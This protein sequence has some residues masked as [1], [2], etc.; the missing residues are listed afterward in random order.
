MLVNGKNYITI[1]LENNIVKTI[2]QNLLPHKFEIVELK[3]VED[4]IQAIN[5]MLLRGAP[6]IGVAAAYGIYLAVKEYEGDI[7]VF[8]K[9][10]S[11]KAVKIKSTRPTTVNLSN[12]VDKSL[13]FIKKEKDIKSKIK[14]ALNFALN[15][16]KSEIDSCKK[17]GEY[18]LDIIKKLDKNNQINILTHCNAGW[19]ACIDYGTATAPI[20]LAKEKGID[21]HVWVEETRPRNQ[22]ASLTAWEFEQNNIPY[23][24]IT[25]NAGGY[26]MQKGLVD[27]V[28]VG[29]DRTTSIGDVC[30]KI[31]TY[32]TAL[33]AKDNNIPFYAALPYSSFDFSIKNGLKEISIEERN[34]DEVKYISGKYKDDIIKVLLTPE[35]SPAKNYG[36]DITPA[37]LVTGLITDRGVFKPEEVHKIS[38]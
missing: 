6:L 2:N 7:S 9:Y 36:F 33:A 17:I 23:T 12:A 30:N 4:V 24:I 37:R 18:G 1:W 31:G 13:S 25:D 10:I 22:G 35:N 3:S 19:L 28:I 11:E 15:L 32:K 38:N 21:I 16:S 27:I 26:V 8:D 29:S 20:Y 14:A 5:N 34:P